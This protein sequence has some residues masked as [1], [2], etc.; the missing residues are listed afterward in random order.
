MQVLSMRIASKG[1]SEH[2]RFRTFLKPARRKNCVNVKDTGT[3]R[4]YYLFSLL[5]FEVSLFHA[6][7]FFLVIYFPLKLHEFMQYF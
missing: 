3:L 4:V 7:C 6:S 5:K 1:L 2:A